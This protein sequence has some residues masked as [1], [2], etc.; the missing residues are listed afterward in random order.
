MEIDK[1]IPNIL[2]LLSKNVIL[3]IV[4]PSGSGKTTNLPRYI[5]KK[6]TV[7]VVVSDKKI[8]ESLNKFKFS[9][10]R[11]FSYSEY[12]RGLVRKTI[13]FPEVLIVDENDTFSID[14]YLIVSLWKTE[15]GNTNKLILT[16]N[17]PLEIFP[18]EPT[19]IVNR[20]IPVVEEIRYTQDY[21]DVKDLIKNLC[22][23]VYELN[24]SISKDKAFLIFVPNGSFGKEIKKILSTLLDED[25]SLIYKK[26]DGKELDLVFNTKGTKRKII[27][28]DDMAKTTIS[29]S[30]FG[31]I[32][33]TMKSR[34]LLPTITGGCVY[35]DVYISKRDAA[36]RS[37][38]SNIDSITYRFISKEKY[39][40]LDD[41]TEEYI[42]RVPLHHLIID[43][44]NLGLNPYKVLFNFP[45][46][47]I[48]FVTDLFIK[49]GIMDINLKITQMGK[50][51]RK[52]PFG[53]RNSIFLYNN[54]SY[55]SLLWVSVL[56]NYNDNI[57]LYS[58]DIPESK[59]VVDYTFDILD[60]IKL[61][62]NRFR[63]NS[64]METYLYIFTSFL[65][66]TEYINTKDKEEIKNW[67][68][69]N[70]ISF[71][72]LNS[73]LDSI[74]KTNKLLNIEASTFIVEQYIRSIDDYV[75]NLYLDRKC[76]LN[77][78]KDIL[79]QYFDNVGN[80]YE[81]N[82]NS[83]NKLEEKRFLEIYGLV[84]SSGSNNLKTID[85]SYVSPESLRETFP[86]PED[87][88]LLGD[89]YGSM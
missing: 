12:L 17:L 18:T 81:I 26:D 9:N 15:S 22:D 70:Y 43:I 39:E 14:S 42:F 21:E 40:S 30:N 19:Y 75:K 5:G 61:Y 8:A 69:A 24:F 60:K 6:Y 38:R 84:T 41:Y 85:V 88:V 27:L 56:E 20:L 33:D 62:F 65:E 32:F 2:D 25:L 68:R 76:M 54:M 72:Y 89:D 7:D 48:K 46:E 59:G 82:P 29:F 77:L 47:D 79:A 66:E 36:L 64:D 63:G 10:V 80:V 35:K 45:F 52:W 23:K 58:K 31:V 1:D 74:Q 71:E 53:L 55:P 50:T 83:I 16:S 51:I 57:F 86:E 3:K 67:S 34:T 11:Y 4:A 87:A 44:Y 49:W 28:S 37:G 78:G 73:V 13:K